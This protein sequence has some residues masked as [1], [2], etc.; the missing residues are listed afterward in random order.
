[1]ATN[2]RKPGGPIGPRHNELLIQVRSLKAAGFTYEEI[3]LKLGFTR[4]NATY[5][6]QK[7]IKKSPRKLCRECLQA[8]QPEPP[9]IRNGEKI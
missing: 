6:G 7:I 9:A 1:M 3:G 8:L 4:Q 2:T 5:Y